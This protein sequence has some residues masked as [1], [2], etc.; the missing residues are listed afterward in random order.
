MLDRSGIETGVNLKEIV[1][2]TNWLENQLGRSVPAMVPK[3]GIFPE[4]A[5]INMQ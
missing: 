2:T 3:A 4:N 1:K 5:E